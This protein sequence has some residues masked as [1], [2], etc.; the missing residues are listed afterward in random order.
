MTDQLKSSRSEQIQAWI[1]A[2][3]FVL[4]FFYHFIGL[5]TVPILAVWF[6]STQ[7]P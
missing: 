6:V 3:A 2:L 7:R 1:I 4:G 5:W